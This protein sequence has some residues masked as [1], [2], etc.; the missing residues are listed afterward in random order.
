M[1][2]KNERIQ[3]LIIRNNQLKYPNI[4]TSSDTLG[5]QLFFLLTY[6]QSL[7]YS[8]YLSKP[9][10]SCVQ[11][12]CIPEMLYSKGMGMPER[13]LLNTVVALN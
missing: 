3:N 6:H 9:V 4:C 8:Q 7:S 12:V 11:E 10:F 1:N 5:I 13:D 2:H